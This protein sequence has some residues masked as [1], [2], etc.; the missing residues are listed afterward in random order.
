MDNSTITAIERLISQYNN[1]S[2]ELFAATV[3]SLAIQ[4]SHSTDKN[5]II[6]KIPDAFEL[7]QV[8]QKTISTKKLEAKKH[9]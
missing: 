4:L 1:H 3:V 7:I 6:T 8:A 9:H 5:S 2:D